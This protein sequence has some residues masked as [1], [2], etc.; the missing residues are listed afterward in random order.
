MERRKRSILI[1]SSGV[2]GCQPDKSVCSASGALRLSKAAVGQIATQCPQATQLRGDAL[3]WPFSEDTAI[4]WEGHTSA[5][6]PHLVQLFLSTVN[7]GIVQPPFN[8]KQGA[9]PLGKAP[10][11]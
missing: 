6:A 10:Q 11:R 7:K 3:E 5:Q 1:I 4:S 2:G 9:F 8:D